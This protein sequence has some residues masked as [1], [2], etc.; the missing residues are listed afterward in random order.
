MYILLVYCCKLFV[1]N[2]RNEQYKVLIDTSLI[3]LLPSTVFHTAS[4]RYIDCHTCLQFTV[5]SSDDK[6][7]NAAAYTIKLMRPHK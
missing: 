7:F 3:A 6:L 2:A 1:D 4:A 5:C